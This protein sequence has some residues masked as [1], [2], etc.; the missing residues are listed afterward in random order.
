M[1]GISTLANKNGIFCLARNITEFTLTDILFSREHLSGDKTT[2]GGIT[3]DRDHPYVTATSKTHRLPPN[4][5]PSGFCLTSLYQVIC[6]F[7]KFCQHNVNWKHGDR[8][9]DHLQSKLQGHFQTGYKLCALCHLAS[10]A[11]EQFGM[12]AVLKMRS[13]E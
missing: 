2:T 11:P 8:C 3:N 4:T 7:V 1:I 5:K 6:C 13:A 9:K 12:D 10:V